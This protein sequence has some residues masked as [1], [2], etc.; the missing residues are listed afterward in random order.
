V[1]H[2]FIHSSFDR[3]YKYFCVL[4]L[5]INFKCFNRSI[6]TQ[7]VLLQ[8][9]VLLKLHLVFNI[10]YNTTVKGALFLKLKPLLK[11]LY[12]LFPRRLFVPCLVPLLCELLKCSLNTVI[13]ITK[14]LKMSRK[15]VCQFK[16][17]FFR[18]C[19][20]MQTRGLKTKSPKK[21]K[22]SFYSLRTFTKFLLKSPASYTWI[23]FKLRTN[24]VVF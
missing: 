9:C 23:D 18:L 13:W 16:R 8:V 17:L 6:F 21:E 19:L 24:K 2:A 15:K 3:S 7:K 10:F 5:F 4:K 11:E 1:N 12:F 20:H 14:M 22:P